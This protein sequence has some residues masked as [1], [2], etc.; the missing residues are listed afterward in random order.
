MKVF[1]SKV[2]SKAKKWQ[3]QTDHIY[4]KFI[5]NLNKYS[6]VTDDQYLYKTVNVH[7]FTQPLLSL[8]KLYLQIMSKIHSFLY[9][10]N[11]QRKQLYTIAFLV[12]HYVTTCGNL[13]GSDL[14]AM[15]CSLI[16]PTIWSTT[17]ITFSLKEYVTIDCNNQISLI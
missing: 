7:R 12:E 9:W 1:D 15:Q 13:R 5:Y 16:L 2:W 3:R 8:N 14:S 11:M 10:E 17:V 4:I 6:R